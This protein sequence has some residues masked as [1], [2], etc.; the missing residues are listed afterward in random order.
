MAVMH[1]VKE[2]LLSSNNKAIRKCSEALYACFLSFVNG[3]FMAFFHEKPWMSDRRY[4]EKL[5]YKRFGVKPDLDNPKTFNEKNNWRKLH[6]RRDIYTQMVDKYRAKEF[7]AE[8]C[9]EGHTAR[10]LGVWDDPADIDFDALPDQFV[11]KPNHA[12]G[13][14]VCRDKSTFDKK[15][16]VKELKKALKI[17]YYLASREWPYKNVPRKVIVEEYMGENLT[18]YKNYCFNGKLQ[19]TFVWSNE[20]RADGRKPQAYFCGAYDRSWKKNE[21]AIDYPTK[22]IEYPRPDCYEQMVEIAEKM[23]KNIPFVRVDCYCING[24]VYVGEMTFFPWGGFMKFKD[25]TWDDKFGEL[26]QLPCDE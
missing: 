5:Y 4:I 22:G 13:I 18:D 11:L 6:D 24:Q 2:H 26:E 9:G 1:N 25:K 20:S 14:I 17:N 8:R 3:R 19:Y 10:L 7:I 12:G 21:I 23:S 15:K 16:A